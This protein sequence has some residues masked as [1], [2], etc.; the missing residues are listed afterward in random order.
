MCK[1]MHPLASYEI[2]CLY[3]TILDKDGGLLKGVL[4]AGLSLLLLCNKFNKHDNRTYYRCRCSCSI[5]SMLGTS[6]CEDFKRLAIK[7]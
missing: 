4:S 6:T 5:D 1:E 3:A 7:R 2:F